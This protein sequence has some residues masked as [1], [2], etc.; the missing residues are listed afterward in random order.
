MRKDYHNDINV[1]LCFVNGE[2]FEIEIN[3]ELAK[4]VKVM[5]GDY[6]LGYLFSVNEDKFVQQVTHELN[7]K[8]K[9]LSE[10][11]LKLES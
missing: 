5:S 8:I 9:E 2:E 3:V 10:E 6:A 4:I 1:V 11:I 7:S